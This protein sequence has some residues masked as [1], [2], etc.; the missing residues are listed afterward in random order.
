MAGRSRAALLPGF[1]T[2]LAQ[3]REA[4]LFRALD[5][6]VDIAR[7]RAH[8][9][10]A[11]GSRRPVRVRYCFDVTDE[12]QYEL[13]E[14]RY[15]KSRIRVVTVRRGPDQHDLRDLTVAVALE[16]EFDAVHTHGD[17]AGVIATDTMKNT[18]YAFASDRLTGSPEAFALELARHFI[19]YDVCGRA[20]IDVVEH[21]WSRVTTRDGMAPDAFVRSGEYARL[22]SRGGGSR[23]RGRDHGRDRRP[24]GHED[25]EVGVLRLRSRPVHDPRGGR[26]PAHGDQGPCDLGL[27]GRPRRRR[28]VRLRRCLESRQPNR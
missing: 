17:N 12:G 13:G 19:A 11:P 27:P 20:L 5:A 6:V 26:R 15:G 18:V 4:E 22:A 23:R 21:P 25:H 16:G 8:A 1:E 7:D 14:N 9:G 10:R 24:H 2:A 3:E 28:G